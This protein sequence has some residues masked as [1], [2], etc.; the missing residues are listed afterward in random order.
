MKTIG[1]CLL[2]DARIPREEILS[3]QA[4]FFLQLYIGYCHL[5]SWQ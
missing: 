1:L 3:P 4:H 5:F 2:S